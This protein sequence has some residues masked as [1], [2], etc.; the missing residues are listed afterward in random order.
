MMSDIIITVTPSSKLSIYSASSTQG[1][2]APMLTFVPNS[3]YISFNSD[4]S[5]VITAGTY[6]APISITG[7]DNAAFL[8][9]INVNLTSTGF[10]FVPST[11][12]LPIGFKSQTFQV[13][14]DSDL[15]PVTYFYQAT[16][17]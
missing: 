17:Q 8:S 1:N 16:K 10:T 2:S 4:Q 14:A 11:V 3:R 13:G 6:S 12:F 15:V 9:N 7:S 5:I